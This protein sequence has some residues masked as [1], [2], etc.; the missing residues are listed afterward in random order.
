MSDTERAAVSVI[1][2]WVRNWPS[3]LLVIC[4]LVLAVVFALVGVLDDWV[5][6][7]LAFT[8]FAIAIALVARLKPYLHRAPGDRRLSG[9]EDL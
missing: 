2:G 5:R 4:F 3:W 9:E 8:F 7:I 1:T 6:A